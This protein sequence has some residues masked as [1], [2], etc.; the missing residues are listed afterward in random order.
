MKEQKLSYS[1]RVALSFMAATAALT[2]LV[3]VFIYIVVHH[4]V[5]NDL[6]S[7]LR[8]E[9]LE[10][11]NN[12]VVLSDQVIFA[13]PNEW[14]EREH[15][16][17]EVNPI[18]I[19][20][21]DS[22]GKV[23]KRSPNLQDG[24]LSIFKNISSDYFFDSHLANATI[25]QLQ[26]PLKNTRGKALG[27]ISVAMPLSE[28]HMVLKNLRLILILIF[29]FVLLFLYFV[30]L[31]MSERSIRPVLDLTCAAQ[32]M[33]QDNF[34]NP[35]VLPKRKD[36]LYTLTFSVN[37]LVEKLRKAAVKERQFAIEASHELRTPLSVLRG[38]IEV[39][40]RKQRQSEYY[41]DKAYTALIEVNKMT[42]LT[43]QLLFL[44]Q[45]ENNQENI[46]LDHMNLSQMV[47]EISKSLKNI[48]DEKSLTIDIQVPKELSFKTNKFMFVSLLRTF[49]IQATKH[50]TIGQPVSISASLSENLL[51]IDIRD[52]GIKMDK[53]ELDTINGNSHIPDLNPNEEF[54]SNGL[55]LT[56]AGRFAR[57]L[58]ISVKALDE[59]KGNIISLLINNLKDQKF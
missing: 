24:Y 38:T 30:T 15:G 17:I 52:N 36:E 8:A 2:L 50:S 57:L 40:L 6:K 56:I 28:T 43:E 35:I 11:T 9:S 3:F 33:T 44:Y 49:I 41:V 4:T 42:D 18:F 39:M 5:Y 27:Y 54:K 46:Q 20:Y 13:N 22:T 47:E 53:E 37:Q 34:E 12:I 59:S 25:Y 26:V 51:W 7:D 55:G 1:R 31:F 21:T 45:F 58:N 14:L 19:Q 23:L 16:Q 48:M 10:L 32:K 29:P